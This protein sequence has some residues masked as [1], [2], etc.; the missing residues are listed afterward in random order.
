MKIWKEAQEALEAVCTPVAGAKTYHTLEDLCHKYNTQALVF[1]GE[2]PAPKYAVP[3]SESLPRTDLPFIFL[4]EVESLNPSSK[5]KF[6]VHTVV[7]PEYVSPRKY[8]CTLCL[9]VVSR[10]SPHRGC[11]RRRTCYLC[12]RK[13]LDPQDAYTSLASRVHCPS[14]LSKDH[15]SVK[16]I[17]QQ[18]PKCKQKVATL[19]CMKMH[20]RKCGGQILCPKCVKVIVIHKGDTQEEKLAGHSCTT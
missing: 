1:S 6:H 17:E 18:C 12:K 20:R 14:K 2:L 11:G 4:Q 16:L 8:V 5:V 10:G 3:V 15:P 9:Q 7:L 19:C 13:L